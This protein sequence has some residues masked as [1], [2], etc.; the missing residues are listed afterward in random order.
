[1]KADL[2]GAG[3][4][5][6]SAPAITAGVR[7]AGP[8]GFTGAVT[9][10]STAPNGMVERMPAGTSPSA[11]LLPATWISGAADGRDRH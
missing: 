6:P 5:S 8:V 3:D 9:T 2:T 7:G 4:D 10:A 1:M 11:P